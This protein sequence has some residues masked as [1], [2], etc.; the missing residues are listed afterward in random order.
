MHRLSHIL[1]IV[2]LSCLLGHAQDN[3]VT[4]N[5]GNDRTN[6]TLRELQLSPATVSAATFGKLAAFP[7]DGQVYAQPLYAGGLVIP[8]VGTRNVLFVATMHN[9]VYAFDADSTSAPVVLWQASLGTAVP[10]PLLFGPYG[11]IGGEVGILSTPVVDLQRGLIYV[12][13]DNLELGVP[14]F[15]LHALDLARGSEQ[16]GG[17]VAITGAVRG[18]GSSAS[19]DGIIAFDPIQHLQR[20]ALL[21]ANGAV[22]I[23]FGSH[24]DMSPYHGWLMTYDASDLTRQLGLYMSTPNGD[25]GSFWQSGRGLAADDRGNIYGITGNGDFDGVQNFGQ[26]FVKFTGAA[27]V[28]VGSFTPADWKSMSDGD[29]DLAAGPALISGTH[30]EIGADKAG[31]VYLLDGDAMGEPGSQDSSAFQIFPVSQG[32]IFNFAV[33]S[34]PGNTYV[35]VQARSDPITCFRITAAGFNPTPVSAG[36]SPVRWVRIGMTLSA[37]GTEDGSGILWETAG[38]FNDTTAPGALHAYDASNLARELWNSDMNPDRDSM[39]P[40]IKFVNPTVANGKVYVPSFNNTVVVYGLLTAGGSVPSQPLIN[41]IASAAGFPIDAVSPG[42]VIAVFGANL[43]PAIPSGAQLDA[44]GT[45]ATNTADTQVLF[46]GVPGP[47]VSAGAVQVQAI[48]PFGVSSQATQV[49]VQYQGRGSNSLAMT[50]AESSPGIFSLDASGTGQAFVL[51]RDN[52]VNS[53]KN[54]AAA[55][56]VV[57]LYA[58]GAGRLSPPGVDGTVVGAGN[59][60][61]PVLP[62]SAE[63]GGQAATVLYAGGAPGM[64]EGILQVNLEIPRGAPTGPA[65][66]L[67]LRIGD[68]SSQPGLTVAVRPPD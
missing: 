20:P 41:S 49:Q 50:V 32:S 5:G 11:D 66:P 8:G 21:L 1:P 2:V 16:L 52:S 12:V 61:R 33:W 13:T 42:Q 63:V 39:G 34:R 29:A 65:V 30:R 36:S 64:V 59:L 43:G 38:N 27:P 40:V 37:N 54:P 68:R 47:I 46:D 53:A 26:S 60:P 56:S 67:V 28:R 23:A 15:Y 58:T 22:Y 10:A 24:G 4:A 62:V 3:I 6:A 9:T 31:N 48:V 55:G 44:S 57:T 14:V 45:V 19:A 25:G 17:P 51:H 7:V 18:T 35:Y